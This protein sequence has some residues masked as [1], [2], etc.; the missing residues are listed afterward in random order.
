MALILLSLETRTTRRYR[1][2]SATN[3]NRGGSN[4]GSYE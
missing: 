3:K 4:G 1:L 2:S